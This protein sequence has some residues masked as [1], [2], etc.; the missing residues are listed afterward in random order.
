MTHRGETPHSNQCSCPK[1]G[2]G[3]YGL[4]SPWRQ[5]WS[6]CHWYKRN[7]LHQYNGTCSDPK[8][9]E[10]CLLSVFLHACRKKN[11]PFM[12]NKLPTGWTFEITISYA[13]S[14]E[15][16][17]TELI[18]L[19]LEAI[20]FGLQ[21]GQCWFE[22]HSCKG[23]CPPQS[24]KTCSVPSGQH[25]YLWSVFFTWLEEEQPSTCERTKTN[26]LDWFLKEVPMQTHIYEIPWK[27]ICRSFPMVHIM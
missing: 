24:S 10:M 8:R 23:D 14:T 7:Y 5:C 1:T 20:G 18:A 21:C 15:R 26:R 9:E 12:T 16:I 13:D 3:G 17:E 25:M 27:S 19:L 11:H 2:A 22:F 6:M 4:C